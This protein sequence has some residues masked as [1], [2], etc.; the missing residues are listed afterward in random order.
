MDKGKAIQLLKEA[1]SEVLHLS[2]LT[3]NNQEFDMWYNKILDILEVAFGKDSTEYERFDRA[4][5]SFGYGYNEQEKKEEYDRRLGQ[6]ETALKSI[7]QKYEVLGLGTEPTSGKEL[8]DTTIS[9]ID[10]FDKMQFHPKVVEASRSLFE[11]KH[12][13]QAI[14]EAFKAVENFVRVK[15]GLASYSRNLM[16]RAFNEDD[17]IIEVREAGSFDKDVQE[18]FKFLFMGASQGIRNPKAHKEIIQKDPYIT[19]EYLGFVSFLL[20]RIDY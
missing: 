18:G 15:S 3:L 19:L 4:V 6:Y 11:S 2:T 13:A 20:K 5:T 9:P 10:L 17:P 12:Y 7:I 1:Q 14:F 8:K 16:A